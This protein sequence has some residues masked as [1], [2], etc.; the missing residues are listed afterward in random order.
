MSQYF[1][2]ILSVSA[3]YSIALAV[4]AT[5]LTLLS[6]FFPHVFFFLTNDLLLCSTSAS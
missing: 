6:P 2:L 5:Q 1:I 4:L 3:R